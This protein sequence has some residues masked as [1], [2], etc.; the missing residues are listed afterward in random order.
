MAAG[1]P[2]SEN[3]LAQV[4]TK[5][6]AIAVLVNSPLAGQKAGLTGGDSSPAPAWSFVSP[7]VEEIPSGDFLSEFCPPAP[8]NYQYKYS[9][10]TLVSNTLV[11]F[12]YGKHRCTGFHADTG[13]Y[14][15]LSAEYTGS[16]T[17]S[18]ITCLAAD[19]SILYLFDGT[20]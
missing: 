14:Y 11:L 9:L 7:N 6:E 16:M 8:N 17:N 1:G 15:D 4:D 3:L 13:V 12:R 19:N 10:A 20:N 5:D 18:V 2:C